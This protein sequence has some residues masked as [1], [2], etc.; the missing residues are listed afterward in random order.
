M[1]GG[2][3]SKGL[4]SSGEVTI[5]QI[6]P[7]VTSTH[8]KQGEV[9][10]CEGSNFKIEQDRRLGL[11]YLKSSKRVARE[12]DSKIE[13]G[14]SKGLSVFKIEH[15]ELVGGLFSSVWGQGGPGIWGGII[16]SFRASKVPV[17][18][19]ESWDF[20]Y[21]YTDVFDVLNVDARCACG[22]FVWGPGKRHQPGRC[23]A[24]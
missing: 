8:L 15:T 20:Y 16:W 3:F 9:D 6:E 4:D 23:S 5:E 19:Q 22:L 14:E 2:E 17:E 21:V 7:K 12:T 10:L 18:L 11:L 13:Q 24:L 1:A